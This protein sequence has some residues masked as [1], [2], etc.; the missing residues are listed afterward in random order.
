MA[1]LG[2]SADLAHQAA[3]G[4][5]TWSS[6]G[7][8]KAQSPHLFVG[9]PGGPGD[10]L[11]ARGVGLLTYVFGGR[12]G[13]AG[14]GNVDMT[15]INPFFP[16][17]DGRYHEARDGDVYNRHVTGGQRWILE[18][19]GYV[20]SQTDPHATF[21]NRAPPSMEP[22][23]DDV[24]DYGDVEGS[25]N[26]GSDNEGSDNEGSD[27]EGIFTE[28]GE[29]FYRTSGVESLQS[30]AELF[31]LDDAAHLLEQNSDEVAAWTALDAPLPAG[32][33]IWVSI[34]TE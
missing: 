13:G 10:V 9:G 2:A 32:K 17:T 5:L 34:Y 14:A 11:S 25:D 28:D 4:G 27:N 3:P 19:A 21:T 22:V 30:L 26:E 12:R 24:E 8:L 15:P 1:F 16:D 20:P 23:E 7:E 6:L 31:D 29:T 18:T 33:E